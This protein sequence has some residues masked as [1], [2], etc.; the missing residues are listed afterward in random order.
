MEKEKRKNKM[1]PVTTEKAVRMIELANIITIE[2]DKRKGRDEI[3][4]EFEETFKVKVDK[5]N[6]LIR[7]NKKFCYLKL[8][9]K[10]PAIDVATK[11]GMI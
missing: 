3:K 11:L 9:A 10:N 2:E 5:V 1:K 4:K 7:N 6:T 8:N